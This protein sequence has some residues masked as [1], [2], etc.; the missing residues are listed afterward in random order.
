[1]GQNCLQ[2]KTTV[3]FHFPALHPVWCSGHPRPV[4]QESAISLIEAPGKKEEELHF[5]N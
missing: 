2:L 5:Y 4:L 1:M 3:R